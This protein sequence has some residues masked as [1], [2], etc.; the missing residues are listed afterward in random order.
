MHATVCIPT[1]DRGESI[2]QT[3][4]S[5]AA[6]TYQDFDVV[7]VDQS[8][9]DATEDAVRQFMRDNCRVRYVR[10]QT[11]GAS[12]ARNVAVRH[13]T[14][15]IVA[16]TDDD[17]EVALAWLELIVKS[18]GE[19]PTVGQICGAVLCGPHDPQKGFIP[20][21]AISTV[22]RISSP[23]LKWR[24]GGILANMAFRLEVLHAVGPFDEVLSPGSPLFNYEDGDMT[25]RVLKAGYTVLNLPQAYVVHHGFRTWQQG[26]ILMRRVG[27]AIGAGCMKHVR[28]VD[29]A[30]LPTFIYEWAR[31]ISWK[32]VLRLQPHTGIARFAC[33]GAGL[34]M[35]FHYGVDRKWRVYRKPGEAPQ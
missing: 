16:F 18:F 28:L 24:A 21:Y 31:C 1:R 3:L 35:S 29:P 12:S 27:V 30:I 15:P 33:Y 23:W 11:T 25:Y 26:Q 20:D 13:A 7:V 2:I 5:I 10:S 8:A 6:S 14:G 32:R 17:C 34:V 4:R 9:N 19:E 22:R